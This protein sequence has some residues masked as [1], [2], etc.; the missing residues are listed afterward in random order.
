M[1]QTIQTVTELVQINPTDPRF[2][3]LLGHL[4]SQVSASVTHMSPQTHRNKSASESL[5]TLPGFIKWDI[6]N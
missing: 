5:K 2:A 1:Q 4:K 3:Q 6:Y